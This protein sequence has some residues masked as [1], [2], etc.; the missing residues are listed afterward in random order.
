M[1]D[2]KTM[3]ILTYIL[4]F[5]LVNSKLLALIA[6]SFGCLSPKDSSI[7]LKLGSSKIKMQ[8]ASQYVLMLLYSH[9]MAL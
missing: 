3:Y 9:G 8:N 4:H 7:R 2:K 5:N 1:Q 6:E